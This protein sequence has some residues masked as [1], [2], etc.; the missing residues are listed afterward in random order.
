MLRGIKKKNVVMSVEKGERR[1]ENK[2]ARHE[3]GDLE[4][5]RESIHEESKGLSLKKS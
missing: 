2:R 1:N 5:Q 4:R 3:N